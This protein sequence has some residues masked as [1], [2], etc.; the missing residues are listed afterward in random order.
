MTN[1]ESDLN[2][3]IWFYP[4]FLTGSQMEEYLSK[5]SG[6][7]PTWVWVL[8]PLLPSSITFSK[9]LLLVTKSCLT[10]LPPHGLQLPRFLCPWDFPG[11][12]TGVDCHFLLRGIFLTQGL[13]MCLLHCRQILYHWAAWEALSKPT[14]LIKLW[15]FY[16]INVICKCLVCWILNE[17]QGFFFKNVSCTFSVWDPMLIWRDLGLNAIQPDS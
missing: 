1:L 9:A 3:Q 12:N 7:R 17:Y 10:L 11:K 5:K 8:P 6:V 4:F 15:R 13:N 16:N 2:C 14:Y